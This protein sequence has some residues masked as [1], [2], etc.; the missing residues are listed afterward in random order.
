MTAKRLQNAYEEAQIEWVKIVSS[1]ISVM[2]A[3][4]LIPV[5]SNKRNIKKLRYET[6]RQI[7]CPNNYIKKPKPNKYTKKGFP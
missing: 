4:H 2:Q 7:P 3:F 6:P 5:K 1:F